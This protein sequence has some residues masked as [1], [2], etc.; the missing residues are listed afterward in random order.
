MDRTERLDPNR[1]QMTG[2]P[3][4]D[5]MRTQALGVM[6]DAGRTAALTPTKALSASIVPGRAVTLANGPA[7]EQFLIEIHAVGSDAPSGLPGSRTPLNLCLVLDRSGSMEGPPLE[8]AKQACTR[9]V[10][11]LGPEDVLSIVTFEETVDL[12]MR[13]QRVTDRQTIKDA[14]QRIVPGNTTNFYDGIAYGLQQVTQVTD[15]GRATRMMVLSDGEPTVGVKDYGA[16]VQFAGDVKARGVTMSFLGFGPDYNEEL[17][18]GMAKKSGGNYYY[19]PQP[20]LLPE[21]FRAEIEKLMT[22]VARN[23]ELDL[24]LARWVQLRSPQA[25]SGERQVTLP[26]ADLERGLTIQH[27]VDLE[28]PNHPL[29]HYR[30]ASGRLRYDDCLSGRQEVID[31]DL[32]IEF[33]A[34]AASYSIPVDPRVRQA[35][36]IAQT[37]RTVEKTVM[38]L[39]TGQITVMGAI[40]ELEKTQALLFAEGKTAEAQE[41]TLALR[42]LR[43]GDA[44]SAEKTLLGTMVQLD[45]GKKTD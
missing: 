25:Q 10:D 3:S 34:D 28:F 22:V 36:D 39:K 35:A 14:I 6:Q 37:S 4:S 17:L 5:P 32:V 30:V 24:S 29:G 20:E 42:A 27:V 9:L 13:P 38:G 15:P 45:Q 21:V 19:I 8:F 31:L 44:G 40:Q 33:S 18:A 2:A 16:L 26:L 7:R 23:L 43:Q 11:L 12:M 41:V 1:T